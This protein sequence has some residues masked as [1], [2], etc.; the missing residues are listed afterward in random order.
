MNN[1]VVNQKIFSLDLKVRFCYQKMC[2][3]RFERKGMTTHILFDNLVLLDNKSRTFNRFKNH[4][5]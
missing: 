5:R 1:L 2:F 4:V 3:M